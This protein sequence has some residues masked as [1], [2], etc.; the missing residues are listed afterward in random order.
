L[1][2]RAKRARNGDKF[3]RL[4]AGDASEYDSASE[5]DLALCS[6]L[7]FWTVGDPDSIDRLFRESGLFRD[8]KWSRES[9]GIGRSL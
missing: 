9:Y 3:S 1:I 5:A 8:A 7:A 2:E 6:I 4:W